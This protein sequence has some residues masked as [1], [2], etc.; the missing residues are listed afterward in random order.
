MSACVYCIKKLSPIGIQ[1]ISLNKQDLQILAQCRWNLAPWK[2]DPLRKAKENKRTYQRSNAMA[3]ENM[4]TT[5]AFAQRRQG[6][7]KKLK[8][9]PSGPK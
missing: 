2:K 8:N 4:A 7:Q 5:S 1:D 3:V 9:G 6:S